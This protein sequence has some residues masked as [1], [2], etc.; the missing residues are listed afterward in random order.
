MG[1]AVTV[2]LLNVTVLGIGDWARMEVGAVIA[3]D[4]PGVVCGIGFVK[5][6][7][8]MISTE[9]NSV[10]KVNGGGRQVMVLLEDDSGRFDP[11]E[12][13]GG[14][15]IEFISETDSEQG[16]SEMRSE[17]VD[18]EAAVG[19][20]DITKAVEYVRISVV[21]LASIM[22][23]S[24]DGEG[25]MLISRE[26]VVDVGSWAQQYLFAKWSVKREIIKVSVVWYILGD[27]PLCRIACCYDTVAVGPRKREKNK[28]GDRSVRWRSST[29]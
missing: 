13:S 28:E 19:V 15:M 9:G 24:L 22:S 16:Y 14:R 3:A 23:W 21:M 5:A 18:S 20:S 1:M 8:S 26:S 11:I 12:D 27:E 10:T 17:E 6:P 4:S 2:G 25:V 7:G 29:T